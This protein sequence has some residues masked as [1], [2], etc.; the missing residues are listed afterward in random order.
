[1]IVS[2]PIVGLKQ[3]GGHWTEKKWMEGKGLSSP[4][5]APFKPATSQGCSGSLKSQ[6]K[7][8]RSWCHVWFQPCSKESHAT[9]WL[10]WIVAKRMQSTDTHKAAGTK[11][12]SEIPSPLNTPFLP[13]QEMLKGHFCQP[14]WWV[15][16]DCRRIESQGYFAIC[17]PLVLNLTNV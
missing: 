10:T 11:E 2:F 13:A 17:S 16:E 8:T 15:K 1:M 4:P 12:S 9:K 14:C 5:P 6:G 3:L 7:H